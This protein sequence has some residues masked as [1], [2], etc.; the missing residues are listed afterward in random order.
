MRGGL[1]RFAIPMQ[2][3]SYRNKLIIDQ[4]ILVKIWNRQTPKFS[5]FINDRRHS[6]QMQVKWFKKISKASV[7]DIICSAR[8][9][10]RGLCSLSKLNNISTVLW[11]ASPLTFQKRRK[12]LHCDLLDKTALEIYL[13]LLV[14]LGGL[15]GFLVVRTISALVSLSFSFI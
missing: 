1:A 4:E 5:S 11:F 7:Y 6:K 3:A 13:D 8:K 12:E 14:P 10:R 15:P 9:T 2:K